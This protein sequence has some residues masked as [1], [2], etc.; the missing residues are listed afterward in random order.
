M[1]KT[2]KKPKIEPIITPTVAPVESS[3]EE[4][5]R[6]ATNGVEELV[7][8][9][10]IER[11]I[12]DEENEIPVDVR[13]DEN[14]RKFDP[15]EVGEIELCCNSIVFDSENS[16]LIAVDSSTELGKFSPEEIEIE[17][18]ENEISAELEPDEE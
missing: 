15:V 16:P 5:L 11:K 7:D 3:E 6:S 13:A 17:S 4:L 1:I 9:D 2:I 14:E 12:F 18:E 8:E 10:E